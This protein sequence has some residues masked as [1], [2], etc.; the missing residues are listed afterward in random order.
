MEYTGIYFS[1]N[2]IYVYMSDLVSNLLV[3]PRLLILNRISFLFGSLKFTMSPKFNTFSYS[4]VVIPNLK[5][6]S[7]FYKEIFV[8]LVSWL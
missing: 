6:K 2:N 5:W 1:H 7:F 8:A 3:L 4:I